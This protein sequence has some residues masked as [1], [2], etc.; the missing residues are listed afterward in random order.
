MQAHEGLA[1][2]AVAGRS[3]CGRELWSAYQTDL[4][5]SQSQLLQPISLHRFLLYRSNLQPGC[6]QLLA[7]RGVTAVLGPACVSAVLTLRV[8]A[9][10]TRISQITNAQSEEPPLSTEGQ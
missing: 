2:F 6:H 8:T 9:S 3:I 10:P 7:F 1:S 5:L 4:N